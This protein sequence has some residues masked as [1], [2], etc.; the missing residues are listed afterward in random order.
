MAPGKRVLPSLGDA[1]TARLRTLG[2]SLLLA[3]AVLFPPLIN[4]DG[5]VDAAANA[6][7]FA[8]LAL[9]LNIVVGFAGLLDLGYAAFFAIGAYTSGRL[10]HGSCIRRGVI[11]GRRSRFSTS[12]RG[13][14]GW[15][16]TWS[17]SRC[18]S[19]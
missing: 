14:A 3:T 19:G 8:A 9:G 11:S 6:L 10:R 7:S 18:H 4:N 5:N 1:T 16:A 12:W 15:A 2:V 17:I 13:C